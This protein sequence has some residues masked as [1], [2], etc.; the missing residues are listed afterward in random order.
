[1]RVRRLLAVPLVLLL[2][3]P[4][5]LHAQGTTVPPTVV[6][7]VSSI[8][9]LIDHVKFLASL[10][11]Q[12]DAARQ[13]EGLIK[14]KIGDKGLEGVDSSRAFG[15]YGR[16]GKE[17]EDISGVILLPIADENA[18]LKLLENLKVPVVKGGE[19]IYTIKT[20]SPIDAYLRFANKYAY[21]TAPTTGALDNKNLVDPAKLLAAKA[22]NAFS[23][24]IQLDQVP[25]VAKLLATAQAEQVLQELQDKKIPGESD[26]E[27]AFRVASLKEV[28]KVIATVLKDG[29]VLHTAVDLDKQSGDLGAT[30]SMS[31]VTKSELAAGIDAIGKNASLFAGL[32]KSDAVFNGLGHVKLPEAIIKSLGDVIDEAKVKALAN[33]QDAGKKQQADALFKVI[34]P[35]LKAGDFDGATVVTPSGSNFTVLAAFKLKDGDELGKTVHT[36]VSDT[37][38]DLPPAA[39]DI[40]KLDAHSAGA[41]KIHQVQ[42][43]GDDQGTKVLDMVLGDR[44]LYVA[45]RNDALFVSA[46]K[47]GLQAIKDAVEV[48]ATGTTPMLFYQVDVA[49]LTHLAPPA[50]AAKAKELF[51]SGSGGIVRFSVEGGSALTVRFSTKVSVLQFFALMHEMKGGN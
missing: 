40:I 45:F 8:D 25:D 42:V 49:R 29:G 11:G 7:R 3:V 44:N 19:G 36:L 16:I 30:F 13:I 9:S 5:V 48:K 20:G 4:G 43:P 39:K 31:G 12:Q 22:T 10:A 21:I 38:K 33:I 24:T 46:G 18:F 1:M 6:L 15:F 47:G 14:A 23:L 27:R 34:T 50:Q 35:T 41:T 51:P 2:L 37:L 32:L 26:T 28:A 17:L